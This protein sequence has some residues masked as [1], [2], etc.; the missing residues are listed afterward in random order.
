MVLVV[1]WIEAQA[2]KA[3]EADKLRERGLTMRDFEF[4]RYVRL[5]HGE[6]YSFETDMDGYY[7]REVTK[8]MY[9]IWCHC[10][11]II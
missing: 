2:L 9:E 6:R 11:G 7:A 5:Q 3:T 1:S 8:R 10:R 4:E